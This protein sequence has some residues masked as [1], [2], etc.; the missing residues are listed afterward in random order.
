[1]RTPRVFIE[2]VGISFNGEYEMLCCFKD[3]RGNFYVPNEVVFGLHEEGVAIPNS[4]KFPLTK[5]TVQQMMDNLWA[6]GIR[7]S[8]MKTP[9][10]TLNATQNHLKD[11]RDIVFNYFLKGNKD[12]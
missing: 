7:P 12:A 1:M 10:E 6:Q 8:Q 9:E 4:S 5:E 2:K 11:M 3:D